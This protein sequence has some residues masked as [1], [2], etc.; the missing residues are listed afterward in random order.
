MS[1]KKYNLTKWF[2]LL[3]ILVS[4]SFIAVTLLL[5]GV[6]ETPGVLRDFIRGKECPKFIDA[7]EITAKDECTGLIWLRHPLSIMKEQDDPSPGYSWSEAKA[8]CE[9]LKP[10]GTFRL[11]TVEELLS[12]VKYRCNNENCF[13]RSDLIRDS[14]G[15]LP[16]FGS[17]IFWTISDFK[18]P[19][20]WT[21]VNATPPG[22]PARDYKRSINLLN[23]EVD[24]PVFGPKVR[25]NALCIV[26]RNP[27]I[28]EKRATSDQTVNLANGLSVSGGELKTVYHRYCSESN[29]CSVI[30]AA[31]TCEPY[32]LPG[33][34]FLPPTNVLCGND[35]LNEGEQC[36]GTANV[37]L[38]T[39]D[40]SVSKQYACAEECIYTGGY[41]GDNLLQLMINDE[42]REQCDGLRGIA[43]NPGESSTFKK[44]ECDMIINKCQFRA[45]SGYC[46][47]G[48]LQSE[49]GEVC[50]DGNRV[51]E[52][53]CDNSCQWAV[54]T[55]STISCS[56]VRGASFSNTLVEAVS[57]D[58]IFCADNDDT[59]DTT[60]VSGG[61]TFKVDRLMTTP[62]LYVADSQ[63]C[64]SAQCAASYDYNKISK[65]RTYTGKQLTSDGYT[66]TTEYKGDIVAIIQVGTNPSRTAVNVETGD[67]WVGNRGSG[68]VTKIN[69]DGN[70]V[71]TCNTAT[72]AGS[73]TNGPRGLAIDSQGRVWVAN[74]TE[75]TVVRLPANI[76]S[77]ADCPA[78]YNFILGTNKF[79]VGGYPYGLAVDS[80]D[81]IWVSN[82]GYVYGIPSR[83]QKLERFSATVDQYTLKD[84]ATPAGTYLPDGNNLYCEAA[85][86]GAYWYRTVWSPYGITV[87]LQDNVWVANTCNGVWKIDTSSNP[88]TISAFNFHLAGLDPNYGRSRG[89]TID[90]AGNVWVAFDFNHKVIKITNLDN[91]LL[92]YEVKSTSVG[93]NY[94][95][96]PIGI[97]GDSFGQVWS[98]NFLTGNVTVFP[99]PAT[100]LEITRIYPV[101]NEVVGYG[102]LPYSYSDMTGLNRAMLIRSGVWQI[103]LNGLTPD[104]HWGDLAW[105][106]TLSDPDRQ[107][108]EV[109]VRANNDLTNINYED[110]ISAD[111][112][113]SYTNLDETRKGQ[114]LQIKVII[115]S[116]VRDVTPVLSNLSIIP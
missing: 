23:G 109:S 42:L 21:D 69:I 17:G 53:S 102:V 91:P 25:L 39:A 24:T 71:A 116:R 33:E 78:S 19:D 48:F 75:G 94:G 112:W 1:W 10:A 8:A 18:E 58:G 36:D 2:L 45:E 89:V 9:N 70:V 35:V 62:Y 32:T 106:P 97:V 54:K 68:T 115:R 67:V 11:P 81:N 90:S 29:D 46:G 49:F 26:E 86:N 110:F 40:S 28:I 87:D 4:L 66:N 12:I 84:I 5:A 57:A 103:T 93:T 111:A 99:S 79:A 47:D 80:K 95:Y 14:L 104:M 61:T 77:S 74:S 72:V 15:Y 3:S 37:A 64:G 65:I 50:D 92:G 20:Y 16:T 7:N 22:E 59:G 73:T 88:A 107:S 83:I 44:Y 38:T 52:D 30:S 63:Y 31:A 114:Y 41:C 82:R 108:I 113:N 96:Q 43:T 6:E 100:P 85:W 51:N 56:L 55:I 76:E 34:E 27:Q 101:T 13:A 98:V 105:T 60:A